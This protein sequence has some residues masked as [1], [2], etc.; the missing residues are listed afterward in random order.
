M[1]EY[2]G[3]LHD[4]S[5]VLLHFELID[6]YLWYYRKTRRPISEDNKKRGWT[7]RFCLE[8][9]AYHRMWNEALVKSR[10]LGDEAPAL[11]GVR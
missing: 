2:E 3:T 6:F 1:R 5:V 8:A 10:F 11:Q 7:P 9:N 4:G